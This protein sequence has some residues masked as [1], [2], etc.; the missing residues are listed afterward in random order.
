VL[1]GLVP[2]SKNQGA[3][4]VKI[5]VKDVVLDIGNT[6]HALTGVGYFLNTKE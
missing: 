5:A 1:P 4:A 6:S 2:E 3:W